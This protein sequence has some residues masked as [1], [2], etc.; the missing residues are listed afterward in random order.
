MANPVL[1]FGRAVSAAVHAVVTGKGISASLSPVDSRGGWWTLIRESYTGAWQQNVEIRSDTVASYWAVFSCVTLISGDIAKL[2]ARVMQLQPDRTWK[3]TLNRPVLRK[4]NRFQTRAEFFG[5]WVISKLLTGNTYVLK[6]REGIELPGGARA[7]SALYILDPRLVLPL[8]AP[9]GSVFY[10]LG[11]DNLAGLSEDAARVVVPASEIIHDKMYCLFHPLVGV[12]PIYACGVSAMQGAAILDTSAKFFQNM[13]RPSGIL[14]APAAISKETADRL[15][16]DWEANFGAGKIGKTAVLGDGLKYE[17]MTMTAVDAQLIE[18]LKMTGEMIAAC[19][20]VPGYKIGVGPMPTVSNTAVLNQQYYD[21][22]L[23]FIIETMELRLDEGLE[24]PVNF[25]TWFDLTGLLRMDPDTRYK[26]HSEAIKGGWKS[27]NEARLE[28]NFSPLAGGDTA[29]MQNQNQSLAALAVRDQNAIDD[30]GSGDVQAQAMNGAQV[31]SL[32]S[33]LAAVSEGT[34]PKESAKAAIA[35]AFP[36]L[37]AAQINAMVN[38]IKEGEVAPPALLA[39]PPPPAPTADEEELVEDEGRAF[40]E[41]FA[42][43]IAA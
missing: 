28:E 22:C 1:R 24:L 4:P 37:D 6:E 10:Q 21:Q 30:D 11:A 3:E 35:A 19:F 14:T 29:Y 12:S 39:L 32:Q 42:K 33:M 18:Q 9:D 15:K 43:E 31:T 16:V 38:P 23:Q 40:L 2:V 17:P 7:I 27:P 25:E 13:Q 41:L 36:L 20:H 5:Y 26:S 8:V 34:L